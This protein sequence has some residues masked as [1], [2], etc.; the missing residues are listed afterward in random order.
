MFQ[1]LIITMC[2][3]VSALGFAIG[4]ESLSKEITLK[5]NHS[6][7]A[8][9]VS[10]LKRVALAAN[11]SPLTVDLNFPK[12]KPFKRI[13]MDE[14]V[15]S[16]PNLEFYIPNKVPEFLIS[17]ARVFFKQNEQAFNRIGDKYGVQPRFLIALWGLETGFGEEQGR[18][19]AL[20]VLASSAF[21]AS[22]K[23]QLNNYGELYYVDE[24]IAALKVMERHAIPYD[25]LISTFDGEMGHLGIR[26]SQY[27][28]YGQDG[29]GDGRVDIWN[30]INDAMATSAYM[31]Q[32]IGWK[33]DETW[34][35]QVK[36]QKPVEDYLI[37][38]AVQKPFS[39]WQSSGIR[40]FEGGDLPNRDDMYA[41]L[42]APDGESGRKYLVYYNY[43][44]L[45]RF[46]RSDRTLLAAT[47]FSERIR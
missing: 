3:F 4:Q 31:M 19:P 23:G 43:R 11:I 40:R 15:T 30:D 41:S 46:I 32:Q 10:E 7:F 47:Y 9:Y 33:S 6:D 1:K 21:E 24:F 17:T 44:V 16:V 28:V 35:R 18:F 27:L 42:L 8:D 26:P 22:Q 12:I 2:L 5:E 38:L 39:Q 45:K 25:K 13:I 37:G 34:G 14:K 29:S 36:F 20:S